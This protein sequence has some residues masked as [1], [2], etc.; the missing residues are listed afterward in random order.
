[1]DRFVFNGGQELVPICMVQGGRCDQALPSET[2]P[3]WADGWQYF[4]SRVEGSYLRFFWS[5]DHRTWRVQAKS[6][7]STELGAPFSATSDSNA[8]ESD[9]NN[10]T[11]IFRWNISRQYDNQGSPPPAGATNPNPVNVIVYRYSL[12]HGLAYLSD[13][14]D[15]PSNS[16]SSLSDF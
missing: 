1:Q 2:M 16:S 10:P 6:G 11:H 5:P 15:T 8:L 4:R 13:I 3:T 9:P 7:E 14:F 12:D